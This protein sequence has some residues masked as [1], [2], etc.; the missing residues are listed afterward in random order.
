MSNKLCKKIFLFTILSCLLCN[1]IACKRQSGDS[2]NN[3]YL[4]LSPAVSA[5][6]IEVPSPTISATPTSVPVT[7]EEDIPMC[8]N[9]SD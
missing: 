6:P 5:S 7:D 9:I 1:A 2:S 3:N 4:E 8:K